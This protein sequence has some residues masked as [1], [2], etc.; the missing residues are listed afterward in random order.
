MA[1]PEHGF[2]TGTVATVCPVSG[3]IRTTRSD[4]RLFV[5]TWFSPAASQ[6]GPPG[7]GYSAS[8]TS[9][10]TGRCTALTPGLSTGAAAGGVCCAIST[11]LAANTTSTSDAIPLIAHSFHAPVATEASTRG[12]PEILSG[13]LSAPGAPAEDEKR[14]GAAF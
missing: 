8:G 10:D 1:R 2:F 12:R 3:S 4:R 9:I 11:A 6:S 13:R 14:R 5:H 7:V